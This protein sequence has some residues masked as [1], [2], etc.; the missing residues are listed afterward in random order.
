M[1]N[2]DRCIEQLRNAHR[3]Q[4]NPGNWDYDEYMRGLY[5]G[6]ELALSIFEKREPIYK[7]EPKLIKNFKSSQW[8]QK[9]EETEMVYKREGG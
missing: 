5:N 9:N 4:G 3:I 7:D 1:N 2:Y 8:R 6:L